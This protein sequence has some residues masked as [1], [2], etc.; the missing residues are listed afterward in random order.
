MQQRDNLTHLILAGSDNFN[1]LMV[2]V[3]TQARI[4][5]ESLGTGT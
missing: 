3:D 5:F 2:T 1:T 4:A